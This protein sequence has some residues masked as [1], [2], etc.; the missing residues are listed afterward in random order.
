MEQKLW[1]RA[2]STHDSHPEGKPKKKKRVTQISIVKNFSSLVSH[3]LCSLCKWNFS[4]PW[5]PVYLLQYTMAYLLWERWSLWILCFLDCSMSAGM[6]A[7]SYLSHCILNI[8]HIPMLVVLCAYYPESTMHRLLSCLKSNY[9]H[10]IT[11]TE[12]T[13]LHTHTYYKHYTIVPRV[14]ARWT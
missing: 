14:A 5:N 1:H 3:I 11:A 2:C 8:L 6:L 4:Y 13:R 10:R 9:Y 7:F 12:I